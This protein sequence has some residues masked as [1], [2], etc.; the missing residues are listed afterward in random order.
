VP[1]YF[2]T[3]RQYAEAATADGGDGD[4]DE[5]VTVETSESDTIADDA[6][7]TTLEVLVA[8]R[9]LDPDTGGEEGADGQPPGDQEPHKKDGKAH[10][11]GKVHKA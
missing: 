9:G 10:K 3:A 5:G 4:D 8:A 6:A 11:N 1:T 7:P 2:T